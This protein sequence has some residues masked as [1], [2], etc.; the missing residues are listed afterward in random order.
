MT[1]LGLAGSSSRADETK[2]D[3][4]AIGVLKQASDLFKN[5]KSFHVD[6]KVEF[7]G[8]NDKGKRVV[9]S[10][11][12]CDVEQPNH[13]AYRMQR[14]GEDGGVSLICDGK[15]L[16]ASGKLMKQ[17]TQSPAP[18]DLSKMGAS[19]M[20]LDIR[21]TGMLFQNVIA[22]DPYEQLMNGVNTCV[23]AGKEKVDDVPAHHLKFTQDAFDWEMW[24]AAE[25]MPLVLKMHANSSQ[26][27]A[28]SF[29][30]AEWYHNWKF[31]QPLDKETFT[32]SPPTDAQKVQNLDANLE[33]K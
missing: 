29:D 18:E 28:A 13:F 16:F 17:Y 15:N 25:G 32:F 7:T 5:A 2:F 23:Y 19:V 11:G 6:A 8:T 33:K 10:E 24:I 12:C 3:Q 4:K 20:V 9:R 1:S 22:D 26:P 31:D 30:V 21:N 14:K 27:G